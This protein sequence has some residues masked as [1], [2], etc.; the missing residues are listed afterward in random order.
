[1]PENHFIPLHMWRLAICTYIKY[2]CLKFLS[3]CRDI[4]YVKYK[5]ENFY[6]TM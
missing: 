5:S 2:K 4:V 6:P 1:M 3:L